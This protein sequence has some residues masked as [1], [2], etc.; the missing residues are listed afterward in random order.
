MSE[1]TKIEWTNT[2]W[3]VICGCTKV[4]EGCRNCF[5]QELH[6][7]RRKAYLAGK[8]MPLQ[9]AEPFSKIQIF[10]ER[11]TQ[12][13]KWKKSRMIFADSVSD[14]FHAEVPDELLDRMFAVMTLTPQH[15]YQVLTKRPD[16]M[17]AYFRGLEQ[18]DVAHVF[19]KA[20]FHVTADEEAEYYVHDRL[21]AEWPLP[22]VWL[23]VSMEDQQ[24]ADMRI[25]LLLETPSAVRFLSC[26]PLLGTIDLLEYYG[27]EREPHGQ[28]FDHVDWVIVGAETGTQAR[29]VHPDWICNLRD[30]CVANQIPFFFKGWGEFAPWDGDENDPEY[31]V[32]PSGHAG[33]FHTSHSAESGLVYMDRVGKRRSGRL[34]YGMEWNEYPR[35][36]RE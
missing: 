5:A 13:L 27:D 23:G 32:T 12:P 26:E 18:R 9:Y 20:T 29:P 3:N 33:L 16:R 25:P 34:L 8:K 28:Y 6:N 7:R 10:E 31:W 17:L 21:A 36:H 30:Q 4:S 14:L 1:R 35:R 11:L 19:G 22:N 24:T 15:T 2:T